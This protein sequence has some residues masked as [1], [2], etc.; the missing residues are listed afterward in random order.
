M[1]TAVKRLV[2]RRSVLIQLRVKPT[3]A[4][5][6]SIAVMASSNPQVRALK[7]LSRIYVKVYCTA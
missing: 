6:R 1:K 7:H 4:T 3:L 2:S 5:R